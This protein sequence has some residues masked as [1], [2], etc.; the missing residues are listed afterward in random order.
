MCGIAGIISPKGIKT[1]DLPLMSSAL[2]HRGPD[3]YGYML[4]SKQK[5]I[6]V[7][8][9]QDLHFLESSPISVGS[10]HRRLSII[11]LSVGSLQPM[12]DDSGKYCVT[13]NG[14]IY[15]Y[16][17]LKA[18]LEGL[19]Y[20]FKTAGDTEV[21]LKAYEA[22]GPNCMQRFNGMW[23]FVLLDKQKQCVIF[24]R[25][26]FGIKPLYYMMQNNSIYFSSEI[27]GLLAISSYSPEPNE[28][29]V[30]KYLFTE[31]IDDS[32]ETFFNGIFQFPAGYW[33]KVSLKGDSLSIKP[34]RYWTFPQTSYQGTEQDAIHEFRE[35]FF[36]SLKIHTQSDVPV[37]TCLSGGSDSSS[38][39]CASELL[40]KSYQL[41]NFSRSAFGYCSSDGRYLE[42]KYMEIVTQATSINMHHV[43][44]TQDQFRTYLPQII[45]NQDEPFGSASIVTQWF[46]FQRAKAEGITVMLD[47][48]GADEILGGYHTYFATLALN[49]LS[50]RNF[51]NYFTFR[52]QHEKE[53]GK[54]PLSY[55]LSSLITFLSIIP[56]PLKNIFQP[57]VLHLIRAKQINQD[58][59][60]KALLCP[61][62]I[63]QY[64][65]N[66]LPFLPSHSLN[67]ELQNEVR[68]TSLPSLLRY[69]DRNS[70][71]HSFESR[72]PYLD[73]RLVEFL[74]T[75]PEH[76]K[77]N[78]IVTKYILREAMKD[79]LP[80]SI[81]TR[82][83]KIGF[84]AASDL[85]FQFV[86]DHSSTL[87]ESQTEFEKRW[88]RQENVREVLNRQNQSVYF[89]RL[90]W[91][92]LN[93]KLW[94]RQYWV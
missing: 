42:K 87:V 74:F 20:S 12:V 18:E 73:Y 16:L 41:P 24:S 89:E 28:K 58:S 8:L 69:E 13:Y 84:R 44:V 34:E 92:I 10:A 52:S 36:D 67:E 93:L 15:N 60:K 27:K 76:W 78:G 77:I 63:K 82:K 80:K 54:F 81:R 26:R 25:D 17:E 14:E 62:L 5:G 38:I 9:N 33:A 83:D 57:L 40:R 61:G 11:D 48:Q 4:Y 2:Q 65:K 91:R 49:F 51:M 53:I 55:R 43:E 71:A 1:S 90:L 56:H 29:T 30:V 19:G 39:V 70:M 68:C 86:K 6:H 37:G 85:T 79:I 47:G 64:S 32:E 3:G 66:P 35:L 72:V 50:G 45:R 22:W 23:A 46:V 21:L 94:L 7:W 88:F 75:L 59:I 31:M